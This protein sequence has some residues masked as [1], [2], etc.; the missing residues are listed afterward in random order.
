MISL[1]NDIVRK[2]E[3]YEQMHPLAFPWNDTSKEDV[4]RFIPGEDGYWYNPNAKESNKALIC[5]AGDLMCEP[6]L[7]R[8]NR[9]GDAYF[10][11]PMFQYVR[12][13]FRG[14]DFSIANLETNIT[15]V[16]VYAGTYHNVAKTY[17]CNGPDSYLD[18]LGYAG[19]DAFVN[20]NNHNCDSGV[21]GLIDT[22]ERLDRHGFMHTG[23]FHPEQTQ[24]GILVKINGI[25]VAVFSYA[26]AFNRLETNFTQL[27][28]DML[29][30]AFSAEKAQKDV[31]WAKS[32]GAEF[33]M[34][35][36]HWGKSYVHVP[37][38]VQW[39]Y[40]QELADAGVDYIVG[41]HSHCLQEYHHVTAQDG[42]TV[43]VIFSMGNFVTNE[44]QDLCRHNGVLQLQLTKK[45][46]KVT[47]K[48]YFMPCFVFD[49]FDTARFG[50]VPVDTLANSGVDHPEL[51][52]SRKFA[53]DLL[54]PGLQEPV[55]GA[56]TVP[57]LCQLLD[58][59]VPKGMEY[60][61]FGR[62]SAQ[63]AYP[64]NNMLYFSLGGESDF[65]KLQLRRRITTAVVT[66]TPM[67][68]QNCLIVPD[69]KAAYTKV[70]QAIRSR[71]DATI[72]MVAGGT[73]K[74]K[75][76]EALCHVLSSCGRVLTHEDGQGINTAVWQKLHPSHDF[77][78]QELRPD[79]PMGVEIA[80]C[81]AKPRF[82]VVTGAVDQE[83]DYLEKLVS[84]M[85]EDGTVL[86]NGEDAVLA[87]QA[88]ALSCATVKA[89]GSLAEAAALIGEEQGLS[90]EV[91]QNLLE[92]F[93]YNGYE[94][95]V[96]QLDQV[97]LITHYAS[98]S[99]LNTKAALDRL[100]ATPGKRHLAVLGDTDSG[101][102]QA[103][104]DYA[105]CCGVDK[106]FG[107]SLDE[108]EADRPTIV[109][110]EREL[111]KAV[112]DIL[113]PGDVILFSGCRKMNFNLTV[114]RLFGITDGV[115]ADV[116]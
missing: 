64:E 17:H 51:H 48:E 39:Q 6:R 114:R 110:R 4:R 67:E 37:N 1:T 12:S 81:T 75:T 46:N 30:N 3:K 101:T 21:L 78:V 96:F 86:F 15:D 58:I 32:Q 71:F 33:I 44:S 9:Y 60:K 90:Q 59:P 93:C 65:E 112:L 116:W 16:S 82:C 54:S 45:E 5:C 106:V 24:R 97:T 47:V 63:A 74:T 73:G 70:C 42:R 95:N 29:L 89:Y 23:T 92:N 20:A 19:F 7:T 22:N 57:E 76:K 28:R 62:I 77:C 66:E 111:E 100:M 115:I 8:A 40:A 36:I 113:K 41:S 49:E 105:Q 109:A 18:A 69:V 85:P 25:R 88:K 84:N 10:F 31:A 68:K 108:P 53:M 80:V 13:I 103:V 98:K 102:W 2:Y 35:Y 79:F 55:T 87:S 107:K 56:M 91:A 52:R 26:T 34:S 99:L 27:G 38:E 104:A 11:Y 14:G 61:A 72:I 50:A 43:P 83:P 94:D